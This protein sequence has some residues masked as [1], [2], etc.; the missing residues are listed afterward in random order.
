MGGDP[1]VLRGDPPLTVIPG[2]GFAYN[3][4]MACP[5]TEGGVASDAGGAVSPP[6]MI[7]VARPWLV[8]DELDAVMRPLSRGWVVQGEEVRGFEADIAAH[9]GCAH[10]VAVTSCTN[11]LH[12]SLVALGVGPGDVVLVP[13]F[14]YVA[15]AHAVEHAGASVRFV[16]V[17][18]ATMNVEPADLERALAAAPDAKAFIPVHLFGMPARMEEMLAMTRPRGIKV[19]EDVACALGT[20]V[21]SR[22]A[23]TLGDT[24]CLSFH[25]RKIVTTGEGGMILTDDA[26]LAAFTRSARDLGASLSDRERHVRGLTLLPAFPMLGWNARMTDIQAS[27]GRSQ[28]TR[29]DDILERRRRIAARYDGAWNSLGPLAVPPV[30]G[31]GTHSYQ[32]YVLRVRLEA[33]GG[34]LPRATAARNAFMAALKALGVD[35]RQGTHA[36]HALDYYRERC[37]TKPEDFPGALQADRLSVA[38]P[39]YPQMT[40]EEIRRVIDAVPQASHEALESLP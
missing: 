9:A 37:G 30:P 6:A 3:A 23:G 25:A 27:I 13:S 11:A 33:F 14:T 26:A 38:V 34:D 21:G 2:G 19:V 15:T 18:P 17:D 29:L 39:L 20:F 31:H 22:H 35:T 4:A 5:D 40:E 1:R 10:A 12:L 7:P 28:M 8:Q 24:G 16:D 32:S 36:V